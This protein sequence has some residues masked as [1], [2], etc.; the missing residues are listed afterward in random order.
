MRFDPSTRYIFPVHVN[1]SSVS[2]FRTPLICSL[3]KSM[4][5]NNTC[6]SL[7]VIRH[8]M[9]VRLYACVVFVYAIC[10]IKVAEKLSTYHGVPRWLCARCCKYNRIFYGSLYLRLRLISGSGKPYDRH[11]PRIFLVQIYNSVI[12]HFTDPCV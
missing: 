12:T 6:V 1:V 9:E 5:E 11:I 7:S 2:Y 3:N 4:T 10:F 8:S